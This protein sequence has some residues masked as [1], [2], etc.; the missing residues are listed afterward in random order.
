ML[1]RTSIRENN[2]NSDTITQDYT[3]GRYWIVVLINRFRTNLNI[4]FFPKIFSVFVHIKLCRDPRL[5]NDS[6]HD[7]QLEKYVGKKH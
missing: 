4:E 5:M 2:G 1:P 6:E 3:H 7:D